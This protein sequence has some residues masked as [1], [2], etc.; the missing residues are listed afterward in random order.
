[1]YNY[2]IVKIKYEEYEKLAEAHRKY[3]MPDC[4]PF[5]EVGV[6]PRMWKEFT[7]ATHCPKCQVE[8]KE[9]LGLMNRYYDCP[10]CGGRKE[11]A[12]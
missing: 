3:S 2:E 12:R 6:I 8:W 9:T 7:N 11:D 1:M 10:K 5:D 4:T